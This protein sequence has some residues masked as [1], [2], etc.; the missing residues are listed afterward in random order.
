MVSLAEGKLLWTPSEAF[1]RTSHI[2]RYMDWLAAER[3]LTFADY[4]HLW[5]WSVDDLEAFWE[6]ICAYFDI[7]FHMP[8]ERVLASREMPGA[9]WF[10]GRDAELRRTGV[11]PRDGGEAGHR[12]RERDP[13]L[14]GDEL[15]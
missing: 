2:A 4:D 8:Y 13:R 1:K 15:A 7:R 12:V 9:R 14:A 6:S 5:R 3:G 11:S 10:P